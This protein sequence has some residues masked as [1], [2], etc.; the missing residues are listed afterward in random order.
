MVNENQHDDGIKN[1]F[2]TQKNYNGVE[3]IDLILEQK[4]T[5]QYIAEKLYKY[6]VN[7]KVSAKMKIKLGNL[8]YRNKYEIRPFLS[9]IFL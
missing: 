8:L 4:I 5:A 9:T 7:Q 6:F 2:G 1:I 3:V